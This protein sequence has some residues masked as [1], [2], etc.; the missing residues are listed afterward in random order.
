MSE[1]MRLDAKAPATLGAVVEAVMR[2]GRARRA[3]A[4]AIAPDSKQRKILGKLI[5]LRIF[6]RTDREC[7]IGGNAAELGKPRI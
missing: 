1:F 5:D 7:R 2:L 6:I 3:L 4:A